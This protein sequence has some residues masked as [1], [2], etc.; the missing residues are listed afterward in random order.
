MML[1][2]VALEWSMTTLYM[3]CAAGGGVVLLLQTLLLLFGVGIDA[4]VDFDDP[5]DG[6]GSFGVLSIRAVAAFFTFF[7]LAGWGGTAAGWGQ[8]K[9]LLVAVG[10]GLAI[11]LLVAWLMHAQSKLQSKG[12]VDPENAIGK[13][14]RVYLRIPGHDQ[15]H[16]KITVSV[17]SRSIE[18]NAFTQGEAL[19]TG[20]TVR[21][22]RMTTPDSFEVVPLTEETT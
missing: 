14:A 16:G 11:M 4:D 21:I 19:P 15:G 5:G 12:N 2:A 6:D 18:L 10:A 20:A 22:V 17:Q 9:T 13:T 8:A 3:A 1:F 7:G